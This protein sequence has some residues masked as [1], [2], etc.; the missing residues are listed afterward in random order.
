MAASERK[1]DISNAYTDKNE[2][3]LFLYFVTG[4]ANQTNDFFSYIANINENLKKTDEK[5]CCFKRV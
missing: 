1:S 5:K 2:M 3:K 4:H